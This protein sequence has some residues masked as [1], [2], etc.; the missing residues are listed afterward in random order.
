MVDVL[1]FLLPIAEGRSENPDD[2]AGIGLI[3]GIVALLVV[4]IATAWF[5]VSRAASRRGDV[6][7]PGA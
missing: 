6:R 2:G 7:D 4:I 5:L 1:A 3:L